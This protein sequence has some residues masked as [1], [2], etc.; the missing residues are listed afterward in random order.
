MVESN[1]KRNSHEIPYY[2]HNDIVHQLSKLVVFFFD[3]SSE[4][5]S[6]KWLDIW[7]QMY[8]NRMG[9]IRELSDQLLVY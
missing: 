3:R 2:K 1:V 5:T 6:S 9:I 8:E 7:D 4:E